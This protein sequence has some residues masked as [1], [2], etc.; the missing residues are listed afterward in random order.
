M[1]HVFDVNYQILLHMLFREGKECAQL[2][3]KLVES[4]SSIWP[5]HPDGKVFD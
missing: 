3:A 1:H 2:I 4:R 5:S